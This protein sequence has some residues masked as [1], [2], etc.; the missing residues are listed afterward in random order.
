MRKRSPLRRPTCLRP[1]PAPRA[2][3]GALRDLPG[4][5]SRHQV[6]QLLEH[7]VRLREQGRRRH[8]GQ[9]LRR[10]HLRLRVRLPGRTLAR[11]RWPQGAAAAA[12]ARARAALEGELPPGP[13]RRPSTRRSPS[14]RRSDTRT[15][16]YASRAVEP[17]IPFSL[18]LGYA[19]ARS[20]LASCRRLRASPDRKKVFPVAAR[21][22]WCPA[23]ALRVTEDRAHG[24]HADPARRRHPRDPGRR[25]PSPAA[26]EKVCALVSGSLSDKAFV[27]THLKDRAPGANPREV[28]YEDPELGFCICGHVY[29]GP[30]IGSPHDHGPS[31][32]IYGQAAASPR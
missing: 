12:A 26:K 17:A 10:P 2:D 22:G 14:A 18:Q 6:P 20:Q 23:G 27:A 4:R 9:R 13:V 32:A 25:T 28:L 15:A 29:S 21:G 8:A 19:I 5:G 31:W 3:A 30:A 16:S 11:G 1:H 7:P 24:L